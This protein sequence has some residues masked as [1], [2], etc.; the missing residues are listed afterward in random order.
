MLTAGALAPGP[1]GAPNQ[2]YGFSLGHRNA[3]AY[4]G[5]GYSSK[6]PGYGG[7]WGGRKKR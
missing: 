2:A 6:A 4:G 5:Y 1:S 3:P 7:F